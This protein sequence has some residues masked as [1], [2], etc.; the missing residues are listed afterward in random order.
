MR[1]TWIL[2]A[3]STNTT[4]GLASVTA[5]S[6]GLG[7]AGEALWA[8]A[9]HGADTSVARK[10]DRI[11]AFRRMEL[12]MGTPSPRRPAGLSRVYP[13]LWREV[14]LWLHFGFYMDLP[15]EL[16]ARLPRKPGQEPTATLTLDA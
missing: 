10:V 9:D 11:S 5:R 7:P 6:T 1:R 4:A 15:E 12:G 13:S 2:T 3:V 8:L 16:A 14:L